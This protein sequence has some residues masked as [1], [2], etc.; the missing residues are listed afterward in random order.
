MLLVSNDYDQC[1]YA[2]SLAFYCSN[3]S[4]YFDR[5]CGSLFDISNWMC[6]ID[7]AK[8]SSKYP[9]NLENERK[10][11]IHIIFSLIMDTGKILL[12]DAMNYLLLIKC[13]LSYLILWY[14]IGIKSC[15]LHPRSSQKSVSAVGREGTHARSKTKLIKPT[16]TINDYLYLLS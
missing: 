16:L 9:P 4:I 10:R 14:I 3:E 6:N 11:K 15:L 5:K 2:C 8:R 1:M 13:W 12:D 7:K